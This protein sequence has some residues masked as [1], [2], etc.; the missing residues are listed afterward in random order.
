MAPTAVPAEEEDC[1]VCK[2]GRKKKAAFQEMMKKRGFVMPSPKSPARQ[3]QE[4]RHQEQAQQL[5]PVD[6]L[7]H[8]ASSP[9][10]GGIG[11]PADRESLG[12]AGWTVLHTMAA[13]FPSKPSYTEQASMSVF[14]GLF[15]TFYP[16]RECR[17]DFQANLQVEPPTTE[18]RE[19]LVGWMCRAHNRVN[20]RLGKP[21]YD[22]SNVAALEERWKTGHV[23]CNSDAYFEHEG[24]ED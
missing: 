2:K 5:R 19:Q 22:C 8:T 24:E 4:Q 6:C 16:C 21:L 3:H 13:Y 9:T 14:L 11:C 20:K 7:E 12:R 15:A 1:E 10:A 18:G 23:V 17:E